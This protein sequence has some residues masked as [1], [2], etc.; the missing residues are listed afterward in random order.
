MICKYV[1]TCITVYT[2]LAMSTLFLYILICI[3]VCTYVQLQYL[4]V[5]KFSYRVQSYPHACILV[6]TK[7]I[8][9]T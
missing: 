1:Y 4:Y 5:S 8:K 2:K 7:N 9:E 3:S 6:Y